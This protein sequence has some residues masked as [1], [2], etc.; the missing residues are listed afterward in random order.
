MSD[1]ATPLDVTDARRLPLVARRFRKTATIRAVRL[2]FPFTVRSKEG[3]LVGAAGD[4]LAIADD[5]TP[6]RPHR[7]IISAVD[8]AATYVPDAAGEG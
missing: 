4:W 7:W 2:N 8:F 6:E 5:D 1:T 3:A